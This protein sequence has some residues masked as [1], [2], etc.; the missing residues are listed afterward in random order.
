MN[1][2]DLLFKLAGNDVSKMLAAEYWAHTLEFIN[3]FPIKL[4]TKAQAKVLLQFPDADID[5]CQGAIAL[6]SFKYKI[7]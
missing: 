5:I 2:K 4:K 3:M 6:F 7:I 1:T